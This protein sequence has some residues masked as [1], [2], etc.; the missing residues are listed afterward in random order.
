MSD[1]LDRIRARRAELGGG[2]D[3]A[4]RIA[5]RRAELGESQAYD[6]SAAMRERAAAAK[7]GTLTISPERQAELATGEQKVIDQLVLDDVGI[8]GG[9]VVKAAQG[10]PFAGEWLDEGLDAI[11]PGQGQRARDIQGAMDRQHPKTAMTAEIGGGIIGSLPLAIPGAGAAMQA[12][13]KTGQVLRGFG[14]GATAGGLEGA[15]AGGGRARPGNRLEGATK[16]A[17]LGVGLGGALGALSPVVGS[18]AKSI[19]KRIKKLDVK[20]IAA[21]LSVSDKAARS[22]KSYLVNDDLE[23]AARQLS[24]I[25]DDAM[26]ADAGPATRQ[27]LDTAAATG[28]EALRLTRDRVEARAQQAGG[29]L[30]ESLDRILGPADG[31]KAA[32]TG[33]AKRTSAARQAAYDRAYGQAINYADDAGRNIES[34]LERIPSRTLNTAVRE[35]NDAMQAAGLK[36]AQIMAEI[37]EDGAVAFREM[38]NVQQLDYI[39]RALGDIASKEVDQFGRK[40][41][42]GIRASKLAGELRDAIGSSVPSYKAAVKLGGDKLAEDAALD[43]G[44]KLLRKGTTFEDVA[45]IMR[46]ASVEAKAAAKRGLRESIEDTLSNVRRTITDENVDAREAMQLVKEMSSRANTKKA[47]LVLGNDA[48]ALFDELEK[49]EAA[50]ALRAAVARNSATAIRQEGQSQVVAEA[51]PGLLRRT[52]GK[53]GNPLDAAREITEAVAG[54]DPASLSEGQRQ[55]FAEIADALTRVRGAAAKR[56]LKVIQGAMEGQPIKDAEAKLIGRVLGGSAAALGYQ[57]GTRSLAQ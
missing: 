33:I 52:L 28:G 1:I 53:G 17:I 8:I 16:G 2:N 55:I 20:E 27:A 47:R 56:S 13:T 23:A 44:R 57:S 35:A 15:T 40:T 25:G 3:L 14:L 36:N 50:L 30:S 21:E 54:I 32:A 26:L 24:K 7:A 29:R 49:A 31:I 42:A 9:T 37:A 46:G 38:P 45:G 5:S 11:N 43:L 19:W 34:V 6:H 39:K 41:A 51:A 10:I 4:G 22:I 12:G 48:K 18:A